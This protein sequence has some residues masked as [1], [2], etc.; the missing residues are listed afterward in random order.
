MPSLVIRSGLHAGVRRSRKK[1]TGNDLHDFGHA[2]AALAYCDYFATEKFLWHLIVNE[3]RFDQRY[4]T[5]VVAEASEF[6]A[7]LERI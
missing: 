7:L 2:T 6:L 4:D 1:L 3:L 5:T